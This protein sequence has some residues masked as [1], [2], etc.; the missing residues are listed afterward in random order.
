ME[1]FTFDRGE[2]PI[3]VTVQENLKR[4]AFHVG[5]DRGTRH[6]ELLLRRADTGLVHVEPRW[7]GDARDWF[8]DALI[9]LESSIES[10]LRSRG[11]M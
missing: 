6:A 5:L 10:E 11:A 3:R 4:G 7:L 8:G 9:G 1:P 2:P